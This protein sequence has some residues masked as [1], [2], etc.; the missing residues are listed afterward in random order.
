MN[1][2]LSVILLMLI[3]IGLGCSNENAETVP[4]K[5]KASENVS[6]TVTSLVVNSPTKESMPA[7]EA[8]KSISRKNVEEV[9]VDTP[10]PVV[11]LDLPPVK[12]LDA[13]NALKASWAEGYPRNIDLDV[14][15]DL[16]VQGSDLTQ[17]LPLKIQGKVDKDSNFQGT[18]D[19]WDA[20]GRQSIQLITLNDSAYYKF[21][22]ATSWSEMQ[23][24]GDLLTPFVVADILINHIDDAVYV[25][26]QMMGGVETYHLN[27]K[28]E[29][30]KF[31]SVIRALEGSAGLFE[32]DLWVEIESSRL[33]RFIAVGDL[34]GGPALKGPN[35][36]KVSV[37]ASI[38]YTS[39]SAVDDVVIVRPE[40]PPTPNNLQWERAP[41][42]LID[43]GKDYQAVI[44]IFNRGEI[45]IDLF[46][47]EAPVTVNN[48]VFLAQEGYYD[49]ITF[50]RVIPGFMAQTGDPTGTGR[51]GPG[52][53]FQNEFHPSA[54][55][56]S[57]GTVSMANAGMRDGKGTNGSQFFI[58]YRDTSRLD[59]LLPNGNEKDCEVQGTS[60]H[61]VFGKVIQGMEIVEQISPR[62]PSKNG[63]P[64]D[65]I[66][67]ITI[68]IK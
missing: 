52:Y 22:E 66:E 24:A 25:N 38:Q 8:A 56:D 58:T 30:R 10:T 48:F 35:G 51:G 32:V 16:T 45:L 41:E 14:S 4:S 50:H 20:N 9:V 31:G 68:V 12:A 34:V 39:W 17:S 46:E 29:S 43:I 3:V 67:S 64:G 28:I 65:S 60:C 62:D 5:N 42:F 44:K 36:E 40:L 59:G 19:S 53:S 55:H 26:S 61:S 6:P 33:G 27:G 63:P 13:M 21:R 37:D 47:D 54:R 2:M 18:L 23:G 7:P 11:L 57:V 15:M 49:G 1:K